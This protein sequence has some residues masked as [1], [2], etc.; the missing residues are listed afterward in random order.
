MRYVARF[1]SIDEVV[2]ERSPVNASE[3]RGIGD[4]DE[5]PKGRSAPGGWTSAIRYGGHESPSLAK[6]PPLSVMRCGTGGGT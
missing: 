1:A 4:P 2:S 6:L 3:N 5:D